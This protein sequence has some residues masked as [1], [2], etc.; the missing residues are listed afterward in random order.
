MIETYDIMHQLEK[1][2]RGKLFRPSCN[3][4]TRG[5]PPEMSVG[6]VR[7]DKRKYLFIQRVVSLWN[8]LPQHVVVVASGVDALKTGWVGFW[9]KIPSQVT[10]HDGDVQSPGFEGRPVQMSNVGGVIRRQGSCVSG[11]P[12]GIWQN[13]GEIQEAGRDEPLA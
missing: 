6:R 8:S 3:T 11:A 4:R 12:R 13:H 7:R 1:V 10:S 9:K 5:N 2:N